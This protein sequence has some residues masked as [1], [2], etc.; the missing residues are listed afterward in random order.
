MDGI[1]EVLKEK[2][3]DK[4]NNEEFHNKLLSELQYMSKSYDKRLT[5]K[6]KRVF[7]YKIIGIQDSGF[8]DVLLMW[9]WEI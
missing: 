6:G 1:Q 5:K 4:S 9:I 3:E 7:F 2:L 8:E